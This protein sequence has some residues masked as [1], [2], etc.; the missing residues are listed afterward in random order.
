MLGTE[1]YTKANTNTVPLDEHETLKA[2]TKMLNWGTAI[3]NELNTTD[4]I[5]TT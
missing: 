1:K 2:L 4:L 3:E 5:N